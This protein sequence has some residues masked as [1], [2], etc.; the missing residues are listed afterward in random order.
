MNTSVT[1]RGS[2][3]AKPISVRALVA[4]L[5]EYT[6]ISSRLA[7]QLGI[8]QTQSLLVADVYDD[9][10]VNQVR[11]ISL[12]PIVVESASVDHPMVCYPVIDDHAFYEM[13]VGKDLWS[14]Q[15]AGLMTSA[16]QEPRHLNATLGPAHQ[17]NMSYLN[18]NTRPLLMKEVD[19]TIDRFVEIQG[20]I[21]T[22]WK[23]PQQYTVA[24]GAVLSAYVNREIH[25]LPDYQLLLMFGS[26]MFGT[27]IPWTSVATTL[28]SWLGRSSSNNRHYPFTLVIRDEELLIPLALYASEQGWVNVHQS[29]YHLAIEERSQ[30]P[31]PPW[32]ITAGSW[33]RK[34]AAAVKQKVFSDW[35]RSITFTSIQVSFHNLQDWCEWVR[36]HRWSYQDFSLIL[37]GR[38]FYTSDEGIEVLFQLE[39]WGVPSNTEAFSIPF[40]TNLGLVQ[41]LYYE[42]QQPH[43]TRETTLPME[44]LHRLST[45]YNRDWVEQCMQ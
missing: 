1:V 21:L 45:H 4:N 10:P 13:I 26:V 28:Q 11:T 23:V 2:L 24:I 37:S 32:N 40:T 7:E 5:S 34:Y 42:H 41:K 27:W 9:Q 43:F 12:H 3:F 20:S 14:N 30:L 17:P 6:T 19:P 15:G 36:T 38:M 25:T 33:V 18:H 16:F 29:R 31:P 35:K 8:T 22:D 44:L 39:Q